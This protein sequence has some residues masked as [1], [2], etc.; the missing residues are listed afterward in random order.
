MTLSTHFLLTSSFLNE[1]DHRG[2]EIKSKAGFVHW[3]SSGSWDKKWGCLFHNQLCSLLCTV[4]LHLTKSWLTPP[5]SFCQA[6]T[7]CERVLCCFH[8]A[9]RSSSYQIQML[10]LAFVFSPILS[11]TKADLPPNLALIQSQLPRWPHP[12]NVLKNG[13]WHSQ[14]TILKLALPQSLIEAS[15]QGDVG[16]PLRTVQ[17]L[18]QLSLAWVVWLLLLLLH[19]LKLGW[20]WSRLL[21]RAA[22]TPCY[23]RPYHV[24]LVHRNTHGW[25]TKVDHACYTDEKEQAPKIT[26]DEIKRQTLSRWRGESYVWRM[27]LMCWIIALS[28]WHAK[29]KE[30]WNWFINETKRDVLE[31]M[32]CGTGQPI[33]TFGWLYSISEQL[34]WLTT[35]K[36]VQC[37]FETWH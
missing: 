12:M 32:F 21:L 27:D 16:L 13:P 15:T 31:H 20:S 3:P 30:V 23:G 4:V 9:V 17:E 35:T 2:H 34:I 33:C 29:R 5:F 6:K 24:T 1:T 14:L 26:L 28:W 25:I 36:F 37:S 19:R 18:L 11:L 8:Q 10:F 7:V 22:T